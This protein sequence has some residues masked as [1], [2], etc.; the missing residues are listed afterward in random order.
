MLSCASRGEYQAKP[1]RTSRPENRL[2]V[3]KHA[4]KRSQGFKK[5]CNEII[6]VAIMMKST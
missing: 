6:C 2:Q 3:Y 5:L 4:N 1:S